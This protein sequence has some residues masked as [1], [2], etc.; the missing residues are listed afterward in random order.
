VSVSGVNRRALE[1]ALAQEMRH[2]RRAR[3]CAQR[4]EA[5]Q[6]DVIALGPAGASIGRNG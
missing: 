1:A 5:A 6:R 2:L 4:V 3:Q